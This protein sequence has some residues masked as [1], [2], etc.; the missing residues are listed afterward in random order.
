MA[1]KILTAFETIVK[2][3]ISLASIANGAGRICDVIDNTSVRAR[4]GFVFFQYKTGASAPTAGA[5][6]RLYLVRRSNDGTNDISDDGLGTADAA[7]STEPAQAECIGSIIVTA[8]ANATFRKA[9]PIRDLPPKFGIVPWNATGQTGSTT[10]GDY[11]L[12]VLLIN[13]EVQ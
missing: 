2:P 7:V 9:F 4:E 10:G 12:Q 11:D 13:P 6:V 5:P 3:T 1:N 8:T